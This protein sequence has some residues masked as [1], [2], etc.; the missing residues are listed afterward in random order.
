MTCKRSPRCGCL[1]G[2]FFKSDSGI[3]K[4]QGNRMSCVHRE[5]SGSVSKVTISNH[6]YKTQPRRKQ[7][8]TP[9]ADTQTTAPR[10]GRVSTEPASGFIQ[11]C[12][13]DSAYNHFASVCICFVLFCFSVQDSLK[14]TS[15]ESVLG[16]VVA[17]VA[18]AGPLGTQL[19]C[20]CFLYSPFNERL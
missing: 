18:A 5:K 3:A 6:R 13:L 15:S 4:I 10:C 9:L 11:P 16:N 12:M 1:K 8:A 14:Q 7:Y 17:K 2:E 19:S 20:C